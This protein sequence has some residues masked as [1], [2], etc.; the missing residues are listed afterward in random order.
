M[1]L[2]AKYTYYQ[3]SG[4]IILLRKQKGARAENKIK[5]MYWFC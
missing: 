1:H 5:K 2:D 3:L 4:L